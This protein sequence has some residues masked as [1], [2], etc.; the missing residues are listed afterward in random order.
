VARRTAPRSFR[1]GG[2]EPRRPAPV[3]PADTRPVGVASAP[4][5]PVRF[6]GSQGED[7]HPWVLTRCAVWARGFRRGRWRAG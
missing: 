5:N 4:D 7:G 3:L 1:T 2:A 6:S